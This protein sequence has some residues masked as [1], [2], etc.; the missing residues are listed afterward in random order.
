MK[1]ENIIKDWLR[2]AKS[3]LEIA[4]REKI[5]KYILYED[6]C[7]DAQQSAEKAIKA[8]LIYLKKEFP[9]THSIEELLDIVSESSVDVPKNI[10]KAVVLTR[11]AVHT[12]YPGIGT[13]V[14]KDEYK[15]AVKLAEAVFRW[16]SKLVKI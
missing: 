2:R 13:S 16:V 9:W 5:S 1:N 11:Y 3:N 6:L 4:K 15:E 8:L 12:R 10:R 7:F 14:N